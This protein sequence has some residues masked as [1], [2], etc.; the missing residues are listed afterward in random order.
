MLRP[1]RVN[2]A[3]AVEKIVGE[4][5]FSAE[6][7]EKMIIL[8]NEWGGLVCVMEWPEEFSLFCA[9]RNALDIILEESPTEE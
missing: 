5:K 1:M 2:K 9:R 4:L 6:E 7:A 8:F 3:A